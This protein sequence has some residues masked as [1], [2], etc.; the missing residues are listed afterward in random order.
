MIGPGPHNIMETG[1][2]TLVPIAQGQGKK[3]YQ[4]NTESIINQRKAGVLGQEQEFRLRTFRNY[5]FVERANHNV[6]SKFISFENGQIGGWN[7]KYS[8]CSRN[9]SQR[10]SSKMS[11]NARIGKSPCDTL[12]DLFLIHER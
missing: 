12:N 3:G 11:R 4:I 1:A 6:V 5:H 7:L 10:Q 8:N 2:S 9:D